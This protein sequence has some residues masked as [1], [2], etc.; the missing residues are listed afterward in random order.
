MWMHPEEPA[1]S[2]DILFQDRLW[3]LLQVRD[4]S[5]NVTLSC[6]QRC[7]LELA[8]APDQQTFIEKHAAGELNFP[9][10]C[11]ARVCRIIRK[12]EQ[13][14]Y[15]NH[16]LE[17]LE[18]VSWDPLS[19]PNATYTD[20]LTILNN[21]PPNEDGIVFACLEDLHTDPF[22]GWRTSYDGSPGPK[23]V[24]AAVM[25]ASNRK[26]ESNAI[27]ENGY[28]VVTVGVKDMVS[29]AGN[30]TA[31]VGDHTLVGYCT[32]ADLPSFTLDPPRG[33]EFRVA[34]A[35]INKVDA[36]GFHGH[37]VENIE[38]EQVVNAI[39]CMQRLRRMS[40]Q[41]RPKST[42]KRSH[43]LSLT[44]SGLKKART[45]HSVPTGG[46]LPDCTKDNECRSPRRMAKPLYTTLFS[47][48]ATR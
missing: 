17:K 22:S 15:V 25:V 7:A 3:F 16:Q 39:K 29:P 23:G 20:V 28:K 12:E 46:S 21:C 47:L 4:S 13:K 45:L 36:E 32:L 18:P 33:K 27:S 48:R 2:Q 43:D 26:S 19:A 38:P 11:H 24:F 8:N 37:I 6:P 35:F 42:A 41:I 40:K 30:A 44:T 5:G 1:P 31:P 34:L 9:L 14:T 10:L